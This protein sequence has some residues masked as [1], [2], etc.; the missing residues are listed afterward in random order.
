MTVTGLEK[1]VRALEAELED[2]KPRRRRGLS[3]SAQKTLKFAKKDGSPE[4]TR[5]S[6][7]GTEV[8]G[9]GETEGQYT[10]GAGIS[11]SG[12]M[13]TE[14]SPGDVATVSVTNAR[15]GELVLEIPNGRFATVGTYT[16]WVE[17]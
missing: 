8:I 5:L 17:D 10:A 9:H 3:A 7:E 13:E 1:R 12:Y 14:G 15:N 6:V 4:V 2:L 16:I 11:L